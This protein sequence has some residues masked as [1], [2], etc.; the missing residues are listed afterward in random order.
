MINKAQD[1]FLHGRS[2]VTQL[3]ATFR[4]VGQLLDHNIQINVLFLDVTKA[5]D[6]VDHNIL[7]QKLKSYG[8]V[9]YISFR[10]I[11]RCL[12]GR[13]L[14]FVGDSRLRDVFNLLA[15]QLAGTEKVEIK[16][17]VCLW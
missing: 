6:S 17:A 7:L 11:Q 15:H 16:K 12:K 14:A 10:Q 8:I 3:L 2:C 9:R 4:H 5:F 13:P 1:G